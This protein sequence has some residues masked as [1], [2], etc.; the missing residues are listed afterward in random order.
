MTRV[1]LVRPEDLADQHLFAEWR[2][3]KMIP[4]KL[5]EVQKNKLGYQ[6]MKDVPDKYSL[7]TGHVRFFYDKM[8]FLFTRY[9]L[10]TEELHKREYNITKHNAEEIFLL[11]ILPEMQNNFW[12][13][14]KEEIQINIARISE[15][16]YQR[17]EWYRYYGVVKP[18]EFFIQRYNQQLLV[19]TI[20][21]I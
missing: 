20:I 8:H 18:P 19:D 3:L 16:L 5:K 12:T 4:P 10:L 1:N 6:I 17:P 11:G 2:E 15:R 21:Q 14:S 7:S 9:D 13:P